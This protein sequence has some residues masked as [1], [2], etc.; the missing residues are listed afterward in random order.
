V[1]IDEAIDE[2]KRRAAERD[3]ELRKLEDT[4]MKL[5]Q[6]HAGPVLLA[7]IRALVEMICQ[8]DG[9]HFATIN[10]IKLYTGVISMLQHQGISP[11]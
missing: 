6:T 11:P 2:A 3:A 7:T 10:K 5:G 8:K 1:N 4:F 9:P